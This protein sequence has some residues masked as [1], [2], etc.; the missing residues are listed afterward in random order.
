M[1]F[2]EKSLTEAIRTF[3]GHDAEDTQVTII[4]QETAPVTKPGDNFM[5]IIS[6]L[7]VVAEVSVKDAKTQIKTF[8]FIA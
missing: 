6:S 5:C 7:K 4:S 2:P 3:L 1:K 8:D